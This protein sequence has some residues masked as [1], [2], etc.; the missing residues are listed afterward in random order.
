VLERLG[1]SPEAVAVYDALLVPGP[2][3]IETL[4]D[5]TRLDLAAVRAA[6]DTL[7]QAHVVVGD[8]SPEDRRLFA[9][10][11][12]TALRALVTRQQESLLR[13]LAATVHAHR[14]VTEARSAVTDA[15]AA[16]AGSDLARVISGDEVFRF[17]TEH[18]QLAEREYLTFESG[19]FTT[20]VGIYANLPPAESVRAGVQFRSIYERTIFDVPQAHEFLA[21]SI[22]AG[23]QARYIEDL[24]CK[25]IL[26]DGTAALLPLVPAGVTAALLV[27][28]VEVVQ[29]LRDLFE[30]YWQR[31]VPIPT[32]G[33]PEPAATDVDTEILRMMVLGIKDEAIARQLSMAERTVRRRIANLMLRLDATTRFQAGVQAV[34]RG[35]ISASD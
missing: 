24:P 31:A 2:A 23:E 30:S 35:L 11:P 18:I 20:F 17:L 28:S 3:T 32:S 7:I 12:E 16:A 25:L 9:A 8:Q 33:S 27:R 5:R 13:N 14:A 4:A 10:T 6:A 21:E 26:V 29:A 22:A 1:F 19:P 15:A 34:R